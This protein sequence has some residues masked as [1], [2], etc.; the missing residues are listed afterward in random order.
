MRLKGVLYFV[1]MMVAMAGCSTESVKR[2]S[3]ETLQNLQEMQCQKD[4]TVKC[5]ER[6]AYEAYQRKLESSAAR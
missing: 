4:L 1:G 2:S 6:E 5:P 3:Y